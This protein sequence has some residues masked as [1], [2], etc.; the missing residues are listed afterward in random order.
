MSKHQRWLEQPYAEA[1]KR[2]HRFEK[3]FQQYVAEAEKD[4]SDAIQAADEERV[5]NAL[6][7][8]GNKARR[9][10]LNG[11]TDDKIEFI[12]YVLL[13]IDLIIDDYAKA[14]A[15]KNMDNEHE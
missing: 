5:I 7:Y 11:D 14:Q 6:V 8:I 9:V 2:G 1:A 4:C 15:E 12:N 3:L 13:R 10:R